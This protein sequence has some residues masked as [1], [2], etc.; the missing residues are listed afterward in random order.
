[1]ASGCEAPRRAGLLGR[2]LESIHGREA[3]PDHGTAT[4]ISE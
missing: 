3:A 2:M 1:M 4:I